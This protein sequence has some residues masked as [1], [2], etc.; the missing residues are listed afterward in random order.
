MTSHGSGDK[1]NG[2]PDRSVFDS[3]AVYD[4]DT[5]EPSRF[6]LVK[7]AMRRDGVEILHYEPRF[8]VPGTKEEHRVVRLVAGCFLLTGLAAFGFIAVY[9][10]WPWEYE[11]GGINT[12]SKWYTP[13]L[14]ITLGVALLGIGFGVTIWAKKLLPEEIAVQDRH[15]GPSPGDERQ[16]TGAML[17]Q[18][19]E[20]TGVA[21]RPLLKGAL[22]AGLAPMGLVAVVPLGALL[23]DPHS[24][25]DP[26]LHTG[27][28]PKLNDG[29]PVRLVHQDGEPIRPEDVSVGGQL[30]V[31]PGIPGGATNE[32]ADSPT[33]LIHLREKDAELTR[34]SALKTN[35][36]AQ[37]GNYVA[38]SKICTHVGCPA[39]LYEDETNK[40]LCPCHQ[41]QFLIT[42]N[43]RPVFGPATRRL[44]Q[45]PIDVDDDGFFVAKSDYLEPIGPAFWERP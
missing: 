6:D 19:G 32:Y 17:S 4:S 34:K 43:A 5:T 28:D 7:E 14:G 29:K 15:D 18:I 33:L 24:D 41:S 40:L 8:P 26:L 37:W 21:R 11:F 23:K 36:D 12:A 20:D 3:D 13:L 30:T 2:R 42:D 44:P 27:F 35:K 25:G 38:Y 22:L 45:L 16:L 1:P 39:S 10:F 9:I 31:F